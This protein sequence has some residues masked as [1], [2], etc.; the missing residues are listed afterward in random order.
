MALELAGAWD[1]SFA[2][3]IFETY[4][5]FDLEAADLV[6]NENGDPSGRKEIRAAANQSL[7]KVVVYSPYSF[8]FDLALDL[9]GFRC[10]QIDLATRRVTVP[11]IETGAR[12]RIAMYPFNTDVLLLAVKEPAN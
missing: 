7:T 2:K 11:E 4:N 3:W 6:V 12:S 9:T 1:V 8:A 10:V 5:L